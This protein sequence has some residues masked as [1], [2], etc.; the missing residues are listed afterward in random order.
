MTDLPQSFAAMDLPPS[1]LRAVAD[2]GYTVPT[3]IQAQTIPAA[4]DGR[5]VLGCAQ[6]GTGKT[7]AFTLPIL[8]YFDDQKTKAAAGRPRAL[9][10][11]PTRELAV[12]IDASFQTYG[13]YLKLRTMT[14]FGG[15]SQNKQVTQLRQGVH[16]LVATPGRL[17]DLIEQGHIDL[18]DVEVFVLDEADRML[19]MGF[20]PA[21]KRIVKLLPRERQSLF[22]SATMP[23]ECRKLADSMLFNPVDVNVTPKVTSVERIEQA[24]RVMQKGDKMSALQSVLNQD[25]T[26]RTIIFT[27]TKRGANQLSQKLEAGGVRSAAIHGNKTQSARQRALEGFR[28]GSLDVLVATDVAARGIDIDDVTHV[29]NF[30]MPVEP[31]SY[32]H[33]IGRTGRAGA[34]G[35]AISFCT[36]EER[37]EL[38]AI[39][40]FVGAKLPIEDPD[41]LDRGPLPP[42]IASQRGKAQG[43]GRGRS[44]A[45]GGR[46]EFSGGAGRTG[47]TS[48]RKFSGRNASGGG[49]AGRGRRSGAR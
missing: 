5:D 26:G 7:A 47:S 34:A 44:G 13:K 35:Q 31:E 20:A 27:R 15:V 45:G 25:S 21:L 22:F 49:A 36:P 48:S 2:S 16:V 43:G 46:R 40:R 32:V 1:I 38:R 12:Q 42:S 24:I 11:S 41:N 10:L 17:L 14:V 4:I 19:D 6:T 37:S 9:V 28:K 23:P 39:E 33:R 29:I 18:S 3:P 30:D 8:D